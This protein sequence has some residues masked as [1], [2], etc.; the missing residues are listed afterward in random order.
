MGDAVMGGRSTAPWS[1]G[2]EA[3]G[4]FH[5]TAL[6]WHELRWAVVALCLIVAPELGHAKDVSPST[7]AAASSIQ[8]KALEQRLER[9]ASSDLGDFAPDAFANIQSSLRDLRARAE[10]EGRVPERELRQTGLDLDKLEVLAKS[11]KRSMGKAYELR[12]A[13]LQFNFV[14]ASDPATLSRA[15]EAYG[16]A[17]KL[18]SA[19]KHAEAQPFANKAASQY[20]ALIRAAKAQANELGTPTLQNVAKG[21]S[22]DLRALNASSSSVAE[23]AETEGV[24][25]RIKGD[26][27]G[28][29][30]FDENGLLIK[31]EGDYWPPTPPGPLPPA[32]PYI[33]DRAETSISLSWTDLSDNETGSRLIRETAGSPNVVVELGVIPRLETRTYAD[34]NLQPNTGYCYWIETYNAEHTRRSLAACSFTRDS[35]EA[36]IKVWRLRL[37][38]KVANI[39]GAGLDSPLRIAMGGDGQHIPVTTFLDYGHDDF[40]RNSEFTYD[41]NIGHVRDLSDITNLGIVNVFDN[42][43]DGVYIEEISLLVNKHE[44]FGRRFGVTSASALRLVAGA[45]FQVGHAEL[46]SHPSWQWQVTDAPKVEHFPQIEISPDGKWQIRVPH[47]EIVSRVEGIVGHLLNASSKIKEKAKWGF[48]EG[49]AVE[50]TRNGS[51]SLHVDLDLEGVIPYLPSA[52]VDIDFDIEVT[53]SCDAG[54]LALGLATKNLTTS[55]DY[56]WWK[57]LVSHG[58]SHLA[59]KVIDYL[60]KE[61]INIPEIKYS[62]ATKLPEGTDCE[63]IDVSVDTDGSV[64]ICCVGTLPEDW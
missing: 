57:D 1:L 21:V 13:S 35:G 42:G 36:A 51:K 12:N 10:K 8:L 60:A 62:F 28:L 24:V 9:V 27:L 2:P 50:V 41:L 55:S 40:E 33:T 38:V 45:A 61:C 7:S 53:K 18:A 19:G 6:G 29:P 56:T 25:A 23:L 44:I 37:R 63:V 34:A 48:L 22:A 4:S 26:G 17:L 14:R 32:G 16:E 54:Q 59:T 31:G 43:Q 20:Q 58:G 46:R 15:E 11:T 52:A 3:S 64:I 39:D 5:F 30:Q 49:A 47:E